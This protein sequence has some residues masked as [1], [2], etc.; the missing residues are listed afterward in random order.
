MSWSALRRSSQVCAHGLQGGRSSQ[1]RAVELLP[2]L[3]VGGLLLAASAFKGYG[4]LAAG[5]QADPPGLMTV[6]LLLAEAALGVWLISG[7]R[8]SFARACA[9]TL[10]TAFG[11]YALAAGVQGRPSLAV[12][13]RRSSVPG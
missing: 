6:I 7:A 10:F 8:L 9:A 11:C 12:L 1:V 5:G 4:L 3:A 2:R 13:A